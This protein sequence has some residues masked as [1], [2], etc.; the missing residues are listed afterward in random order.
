MFCG[1][2]GRGMAKSKVDPADLEKKAK[3]D[4]KSKNYNNSHSRANLKQYQ[5]PLVPEIVEE[6][7]AEADDAAVDAIVVGRKLSADLVKK[8]MPQRGVLTVGEKKRYVGIV[9]EFLSDFKN[10]EPTAADIDDIFEIAESDIMKARLLRASRDNPETLVQ[11]QTAMEKTYKRK[12][13]A[14]ENL[15]ARRVDRIDAKHTQDIS[16][17]DLVVSYDLSQ[18]HKEEE[19]VRELLEQNERAQ[20]RL[21]DVLK[22]DV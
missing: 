6:E 9:Q 11:I 10:E 5:K 16:I 19:R 7:S 14:K 13:T 3:S 12:Q 17:V 1:V 15:S 22:E 18:Q 21:E 20:E 2:K 4:P 8:L